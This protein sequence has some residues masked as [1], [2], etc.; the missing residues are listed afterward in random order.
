MT[1]WEGDKERDKERD[2]EGNTE[3]EGKKTLSDLHSTLKK[4]C[5]VTNLPFLV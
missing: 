1:E 3:R 4:I 5:I 2:K